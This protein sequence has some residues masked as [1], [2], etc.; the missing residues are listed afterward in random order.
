MNTHQTKIAY[1]SM[2][3][4]LES[5]IPTYAGGL[6][7]LAG[8]TVRAAAD[9][10]LPMV[11]VSLLT[12]KGYLFQK[13][14]EDGWQTEAPMKWCV[15]DHLE[16][17]PRRITL[18]IEGRQVIVRAWKFE[19]AG[20]KG[21]V[22]VLLLDCDMPEND[23]QVAGITQWLYGGD[24]V[25]R[26]CQ[27]MILG[28]G[29]VRMLRAL[30]FND[31]NRFHMNE[32][33]ASLL[34]L[35]LLA[36]CRQRDGRS[37]VTDEDIQR[38]RKQCIFTTHTP[39]T[40][41]HDK[42][43]IDVATQLLGPRP[44]FARHD[45]FCC[46]GLL[47]MT[48]LALN[49]SHFVNGVSK[50]NR[51]VTQSMYSGYQISDITNGIHVENWASQPMQDVFDQ[52][53][54]GWREDNFSLRSAMSIPTKEIAAA[55]QQAKQ[56]LI[57]QINHINNVGM[58]DETFTIGFARRMTAYKRPDLLF[59]DVVR[60]QRIAEKVGRIQVVFAGKSHPDDD[61]ERN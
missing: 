24:A 13:L 21:S 31:L 45:V 28:I 5:S 42:F 60:L 17:L 55:H 49:L 34:T 47:N 35:E 19:V 14:A 12:R 46:D 54:P 4:A 7:V 51:K 6:G 22:P 23:A 40:A 25:Q 39:V 44:E 16:E 43:P 38:V 33:H 41:G 53:I 58:D 48:Y 8:D 26:L 15:E 56:T 52:H 1:F 37:H 36:E 18:D 20:Q 30:G 11:A 27:E 10:G 2:E 59:H 32:G 3:I 50:R 61:T 9:A 57:D 29:G